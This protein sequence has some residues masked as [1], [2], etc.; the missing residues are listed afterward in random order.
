MHINTCLIIGESQS[1]ML[2][3]RVDSKSP[4]SSDIGEIRSPM[5]ACR[6]DSKASFKDWDNSIEGDD[7]GG[8]RRGSRYLCI[9]VHI[10]IYIYIYVFTYVYMYICLY[11]YSYK[12]MYIYLHA[13]IDISM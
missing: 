3:S 10:F 6:A 12:H 9:H 1:P 4:I 8:E 11:I 5:L 7:K 2:S 13:Y